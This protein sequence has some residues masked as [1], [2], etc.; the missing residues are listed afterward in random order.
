MNKIIVFISLALSLV[1]INLGTSTS[2]Q[3]GEL[4][5]ATLQLRADNL[6]MK[7]KIK[8]KESLAKQAPIALSKSYGLVLNQ[9]KLLESLS[10]TS[11]SVQLEGATDSQDISSRYED[12]VYKA[13]KGLRIQIIVDKFSRQTD[14]GGILADIYLLEKNT[15]FKVSEIIM[16]NNHLMVKG[17]VYG[18]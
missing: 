7:A 10:A 2:V 9:I 18:L 5:R 17:E 12:T 4:K 3:V 13:V 14:I 1:L 8:E 11:M 15:D 6:D 16:E